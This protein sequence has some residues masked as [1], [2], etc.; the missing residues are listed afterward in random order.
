MERSRCRFPHPR[1]SLLATRP[2]NALRSRRQR[3]RCSRHRVRAVLAPGRPRPL[4]WTPIPGPHHR[5]VL[6]GRRRRIG[7]VTA[8][9]RKGHDETKRD[10]AKPFH[11]ILTVLTPQWFPLRCA[12]PRRRSASWDPVVNADLPIRRLIRK[13]PTHRLRIA[14]ACQVAQRITPPASTHST[15]SAPSTLRMKSTSTSSG[16]S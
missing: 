6:S 15:R 4:R 11:T 7:G 3:C 9:R 14:D 16:T 10:P 12:D 13:G 5:S 2:G 8:R 1:M